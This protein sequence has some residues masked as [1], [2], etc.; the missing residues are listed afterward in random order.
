[1]CVRRFFTSLYCIKVSVT[2]DINSRNAENG[3]R[4]HEGEVN[5][6]SCLSR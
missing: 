5:S 6:V 3:K 1:M 2:G 4:E